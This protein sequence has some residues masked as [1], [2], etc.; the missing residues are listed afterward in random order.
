MTE[1]DL[2]I[3]L[4]LRNDRQGPGGE[5]ESRRAIELTGPDPTTPINAADLGCG[6]G[7]SALMLARELN[8]HITA[9]DAAPA[10]IERL[11]ER[12]AGAGLADRISAQV[13]D[14][15]S[16]P[17]REHELDLIWCES[18]IY[19][20]GFS[21][22]VRAW[23]RVLRP[24]GVLAISELTWTTATRPAEIDSHWNAEYPGITTAS[25]NLRTLEAEGYAPLGFFFLPPRCWTDNYYAPLH[26][27]FEPFLERHGH[28][29]AAKRIVDT[30]QAE[31]ELFRQHGRWYGYAF[32]VARRLED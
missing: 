22:G 24:G 28:S 4:H 32:Y 25:A 26:A 21:E 3:D 8:A 5:H 2:L 15:A 23:R 10:F 13:G 12:A 16:P 20:V 30:E 29:E 14:M 7:A 6:T 31:I 9:I 17:F 18:A 11:R 27:G 19:N 1:F